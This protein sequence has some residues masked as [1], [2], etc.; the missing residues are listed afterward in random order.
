MPRRDIALEAHAFGNPS[1]T[2]AAKQTCMP[3]D[4]EL[5]KSIDFERLPLPRAWAD[6]GPPNSG[7]RPCFGELH[8]RNARATTLLFDQ[9]VSLTTASVAPPAVAVVERRP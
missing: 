1:S 7:R 5:E 2:Q 6:A 4:G 9:S 8:P 3:P